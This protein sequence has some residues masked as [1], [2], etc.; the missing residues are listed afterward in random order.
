MPNTV[1]QSAI[2]A[3]RQVTR[4]LR[5]EAVTLRGPD[6]VILAEIPDAVV[7]LDPAA[8]GAAGDGPGKLTGV[9]RLHPEYYDNAVASLTV[10]CRGLVWEVVNVGKIN[11]G[12]F[13]V[14]LRQDEPKHT[15]L[16]DLSGQQAVW[17]S[18]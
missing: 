10:L 5:G 1:L 7:I 16:F 11:G 6:A 15:N 13:R 4:D 8:V 14:E 17:H 9:L 2:A 3:A 18:V 12:A